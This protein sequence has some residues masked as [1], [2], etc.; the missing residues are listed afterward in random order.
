M[1]KEDLDNAEAAATAAAVAALALDAAEDKYGV[2]AE[3]TNLT[4]LQSLDITTASGLP[5]PPCSPTPPPPPASRPTPRQ[6]PKK[7]SPLLK[8]QLDMA[9]NADKYLMDPNMKPPYSY[10]TLI[11][12]A[13]RANNN[14]V[15]LSN[16]YAWIRETFMYYRTADPA[17]QNSIRH[18]LSL[19]KCFVKL[20]RSKD[21][22]GK[23]GFW[24]L[25][26][27]RLEE[28]RRTR[29]RNN[30][31]ASRHSRPLPIQRLSMAKDTTDHVTRILGNNNGPK[32]VVL[33]ET[34]PSSVSPPIPD[35]LPEVLEST[36]MNISE[37]DFTDLLIESAAWTDGVPDMHQLE[38]FNSVLDML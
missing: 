14:R 6:Q 32:C 22:P 30:S 11:C 13:M 16:I 34:P 8:A 28:G 9:E 20:P 33:Y 3:L 15:T 7:M 24:K 27:E 26:L 35:T 38:L 17:W 29:R 10:A 18:N 37:E 5:T 31:S 23:G 4:W 1:V 12:L 21:E 2:E 19:N 36:Q 25:D